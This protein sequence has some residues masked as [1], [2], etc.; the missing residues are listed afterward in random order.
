MKKIAHIKAATIVLFAFCVVA[1]AEGQTTACLNLKAEIPF[2]FNV[3]ETTLP[4]DEYTITC[5]N[6]ASDQTVLQFHSK[7]GRSRPVVQMRVA[8]GTASTAA[9]LVFN[10]YGNRY[11]FAQAQMPYN[12]SGLEGVDVTGG[13]QHAT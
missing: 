5:I 2:D 1:T 11:Y 9:R 13:T 6:P 12:R 3:G 8:T 10:K 7:D 4:A